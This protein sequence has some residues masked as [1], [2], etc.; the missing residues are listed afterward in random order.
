MDFE[1][2]AWEIIREFFP[3]IWMYIFYTDMRTVIQ[4]NN[5]ILRKLKDELC[6]D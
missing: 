1:N 5:E 6:K 2:I 3:Y 4:N